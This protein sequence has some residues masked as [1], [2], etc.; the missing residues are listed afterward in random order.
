MLVF[1]FPV[2]GSTYASEEFDEV[3]E[4]H[5]EKRAVGSFHC[6]VCGKISPSLTNAKKHFEA[7]HFLTEGGYTCELCSAFCK[8]KHALDCHISRK[9]RYRN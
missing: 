4:K 9:H 3:F 1:P 2:A 8:T 7:K 5:T 6:L